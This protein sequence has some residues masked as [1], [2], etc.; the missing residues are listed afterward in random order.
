MPSIRDEHPPSGWGILINGKSKKIDYLKSDAYFLSIDKLNNRILLNE[1]DVP[2]TLVTLRRTTL[3]GWEIEKSDGE[4]ETITVFSIEDRKDDTE[5]HAVMKTGDTYTYRECLIP[6]GRAI[7]TV[8]WKSLACN[9]I[10]GR[11]DY[12]EAERDSLAVFQ[13][14]YYLG[15]VYFR[16][17]P[18]LSGLEP[19][20]G[21]EQE[22][23]Q[24]P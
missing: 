14:T 7:S 19:V 5:L 23:G 13:P 6:P 22:V 17:V 1:D 18:I 9:R 8:D 2:N 24:Q 20:A 3:P 15:D 4:T 10:E 21:T 11:D 16:I 12:S